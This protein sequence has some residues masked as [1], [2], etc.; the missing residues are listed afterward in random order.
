MAGITL[1]ASRLSLA[2]SPLL[3]KSNWISTNPAPERA[4]HGNVWPQFYQPVVCRCSVD[5][6]NA[7]VDVI[8]HSPRMA[9][10]ELERHAAGEPPT[11]W[12]SRAHLGHM[13]HARELP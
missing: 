4:S 7:D 2:R 12:R 5:T 9:D 8:V 3:L 1:S 6:T 11:K 10:E 13:L